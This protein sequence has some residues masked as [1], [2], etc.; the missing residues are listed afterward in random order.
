MILI[1]QYSSYSTTTLAVASMLCLQ[2][3]ALMCCTCYCRHSLNDYTKV[4]LAELY[5][6]CCVRATMLAVD[7]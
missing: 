1:L 2:M 5:V 4:M 7:H 3:L 6:S